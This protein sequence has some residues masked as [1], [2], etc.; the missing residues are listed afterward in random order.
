MPIHDTV[1]EVAVS[2]AAACD[3]GPH[4]FPLVCAFQVR[5]ADRQRAEERRRADHMRFQKAPSLPVGA[6]DVASKGE[7]AAERGGGLLAAL[8]AEP[9][10]SANGERAA[11]DT[12]LMLSSGGGGT[13]LKRGRPS[14]ASEEA[15]ALMGPGPGPKAGRSS[16]GAGR[17]AAEEGPGAKEH[18]R[19]SAILAQARDFLTEM[20]GEGLGSGREVSGGGE[21]A[22][23][24]ERSIKDAE[25][26]MR[27]ELAV[28]QNLVPHL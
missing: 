21:A 5:A 22:L 14:D 16:L 27:A 25:L 26:V 24:A 17:S 18:E 13:S 1:H 20:D 15:G 8:R 6:G 23:A 9:S 12:F 28:L 19:G 4:P 2:T 11:S 7:D 10:G 3:A